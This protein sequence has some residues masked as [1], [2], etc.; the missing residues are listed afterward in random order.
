MALSNRWDLEINGALVRQNKWARLSQ[1][2]IQQGTATNGKM[3]D[4]FYAREL[5]GMVTVMKRHILKF[6]W[7]EGGKKS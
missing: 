3:T 4:D 7:I 6:N 1:R 2:R 5:S